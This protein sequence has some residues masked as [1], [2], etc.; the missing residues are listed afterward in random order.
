MFRRV[1]LAKKGQRVAG[2]LGKG[3]SQA[4]QAKGACRGRAPI[5]RSLATHHVL[6]VFA[7]FFSCQESHCQPRDAGTTKGRHDARWH[8]ASAHGN[9][10]GN[11]H[12]HATAGNAWRHGHAVEGRWNNL[13]CIFGERQAKGGTS[14]PSGVLLYARR[15]ST[16]LH[17]VGKRRRGAIR[18]RSCAFTDR[19]SV[20]TS[21]WP[22][23]TDGNTDNT[24]NNATHLVT[25]TGRG[26]GAAWCQTLVWHGSLCHLSLTTRTL[27]ASRVP[28]APAAACSVSKTA[29]RC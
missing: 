4:I 27:P 28:M 2:G 12:G 14:L 17:L 11:G 15:S 13:H 20:S 6:V 16:A 22:I 9:G 23:S 3:R 24:N 8:A 26:N 1:L 21:C 25:A 7:C 18:R 29:R 10:H 5:K 19:N